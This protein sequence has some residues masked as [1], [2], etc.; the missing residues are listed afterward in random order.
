M[1]HKNGIKHDNRIENLEWVT[2]SE[3][4]KHAY[5]NGLMTPRKGESVN[6]SRLT[7]DDV[8]KIRGL[9]NEGLSMAIIGKMF[10]VGDS[11]IFNIK[12]RVSWK[13]VK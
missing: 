11:A 2:S 4:I 10:G 7:E 13:H 12:H 5:D 3:N 9:L 6:T 1:N 8:L